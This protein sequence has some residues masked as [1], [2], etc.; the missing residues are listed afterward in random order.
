MSGLIRPIN[1]SRS[2][3]VLIEANKFL[4]D[5]NLLEIVGA[6]GVLGIDW[7]GS[8]GPPTTYFYNRTLSFTYQGNQ[9]IL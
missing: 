7:L 8:F 6:D 5:F 1:T 9:I 2:V 4:I 3:L